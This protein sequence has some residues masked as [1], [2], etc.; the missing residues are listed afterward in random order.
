[1]LKLIFLLI[2]LNCSIARA[3]V[4]HWKE[5]KAAANRCFS[6]IDIN[7]KFEA[8]IKEQQEEDSERETF[9]KVVFEIPL[10]SR[11]ARIERM[12]ERTEYIDR[13]A[14]VIQEIESTEDR[15]NTKC[16]YIKLLEK[17]GQEKGF[18]ALKEIMIVQEELDKLYA[19]K[20]AAERKLEGY[21]KCSEKLE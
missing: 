4:E 15:L 6:G 14:D 16:E 11:K 7:M 18:E 1:M 8:G 20:R 2:L 17:I 9:G 3:D 19:Q 12:S 5:L 10:L 21:L 13:G